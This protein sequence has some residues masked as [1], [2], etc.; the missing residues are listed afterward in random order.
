M[1]GVSGELWFAKTYFRLSVSQ[2]RL[3]SLVLLSPERHVKEEIN[4]D[5]VIRDF[6]SLKARKCKLS[7]FFKT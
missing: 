7:Q 2:V 5:Q 4:F 3:K 1:R 6:A